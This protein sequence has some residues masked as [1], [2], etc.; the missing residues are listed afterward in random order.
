MSGGRPQSGRQELVRE[1]SAGHVSQGDAEPLV[2]GSRDSL[3]GVA[4]GGHGCEVFKGFMGL[5][6]L[7]PVIDDPDVQSRELGH[8]FGEPESSS[9]VA[10]LRDWLAWTL[11]TPHVGL[12]WRDRFYIEQREAGWMSS[13][14]QVY[15]MAPLERFPLLNAARTYAL[16]LS[17]PEEQRL[18]S[19][20]QSAVI[21]RLA[22]E[23]MT[24]PF[25]PPGRHFGR[26]RGALIRTRDDPLYV[27]RVLR[28]RVAQRLQARLHRRG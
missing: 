25:N 7:P 4:L 16:L 13:K 20:V 27:P 11:Q 1:H 21:T 3:A 26:A 18:G 9:A 19:V 6:R 17:L 22:P 2:D 15:D 24:H 8:A 28:H 10:G 14:E 5:R 23:L 12:D